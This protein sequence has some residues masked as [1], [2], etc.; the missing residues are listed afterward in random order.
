MKKSLK[1]IALLLTFA[2]SAA[3]ALAEEAKIV[4]LQF[5][6]DHCGSCKILD[7][8]LSQAKTELAGSPILFVKLDHTDD[9][10]SQQSKLLVHALKL[11]SVYAK[12][13]KSSGFVLL[14]DTDSN[15]VVG[16]LT[17]KQ[18]PEKMTKMLTEAIQS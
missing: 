11:D 18:S 5:H 4:A 3:T 12:Q 1:S 7:P 15:K 13:K 6:S 14:I 2:F 10:T 8:K 17:K 16:K 9:T